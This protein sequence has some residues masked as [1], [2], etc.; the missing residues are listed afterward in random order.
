VRLT[1]DEILAL[2]RGDHVTYDNKEY[3]VQ[4]MQS[5]TTDDQLIYFD[6]IDNRPDEYHAARED[7][8]ADDTP[9]EY[10]DYVRHLRLP[11]RPGAIL[12]LAAGTREQF[13][14]HWDS[15]EAE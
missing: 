8:M 9:V 13:A 5:L 15:L 6:R 4:V 2:K 11:A 14:H 1:I 3:I 12:G 7:E 10:S